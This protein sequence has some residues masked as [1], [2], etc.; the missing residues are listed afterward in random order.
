MIYKEFKKYLKVKIKKYWPTL[1]LGR[2]ISRKKVI[3]K[4]IDVAL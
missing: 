1:I 2:H 4:D 3:E